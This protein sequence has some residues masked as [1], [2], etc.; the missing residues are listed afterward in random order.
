MS[1]SGIE[2]MQLSDALSSLDESQQEARREVHSALK[3]AS[4]DY[5]RQQ[6]NTVVSACMKIINVLYKLGGSATDLALMQEAMGITL[7]LL[8]P[9][10]P[11]ISHHL[12]RELG[13]GDDILDSSWPQPD[14]TA[15]KQASIPYAVQVNGK[16]RA[17]LQVPADADN[18]AI[19]KM[20]LKN[21]K[22]EK[23]TDGKTIRK[24]I[25]VPNKLVNIVAT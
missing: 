3:K 21:D 13:Y 15:L 24:I 5:Q 11:H 1:G 16:V 19:E 18:E 9:I 10:A 17:Q 22:V 23:F 8:A 7:R 20:A 6:F 4:F 25:I 2:P 12:W 14:E